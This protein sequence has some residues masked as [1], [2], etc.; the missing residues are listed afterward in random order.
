MMSEGG[1]VTTFGGL[2]GTGKGAGMSL[3]LIISGFL[4]VVAGLVAYSFRVLRDAED[5][6]PD[7]GS[8]TGLFPESRT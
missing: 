6:L 8:E 7:Y 5:I 1:L 2:A 4:G 3:M